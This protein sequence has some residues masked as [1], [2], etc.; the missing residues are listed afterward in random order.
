MAIRVRRRARAP[1]PASPEHSN[2]DGLEEER[3][4]H[5][6]APTPSKRQS[7]RRLSKLIQGD[8]AR[9]SD[10]DADDGAQFLFDC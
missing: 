9:S 10:E 1:S 7:G 8:A 2:S 6:S 5:K 3:P 4:K